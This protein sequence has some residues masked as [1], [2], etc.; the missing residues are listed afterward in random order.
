MR[1]TPYAAALLA[2]FLVPVAA[3][4][5]TG[6]TSATPTSTATN[7]SAST[8]STAPTDAADAGTEP[9]GRAGV[10]VVLVTSGGFAGLNDTLTVTPDGRWAKVDRAGA[11]RTGQLD[12]ADLD[13]LRQ[14]T[15]DRRLLTEPTATTSATCA[16][17]F[18]YQ[19]AVGPVTSGYVDCPA[20]GA[21]PAATAAVV[22]LLT[23]ATD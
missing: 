20:D 2:A 21:P 15:A 23:R 17:A 5:Q 4:A 13:R 1:T 7:A 14:L 10:D 16:D 9:P 11:T 3:C 18:T 8:P 22:E 19:L 6:E 12:P